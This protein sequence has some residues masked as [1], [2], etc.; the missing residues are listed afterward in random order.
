L[1]GSRVSSRCTVLYTSG[2]FHDHDRPQDDGFESAL[3]RTSHT[4]CVLP[5]ESY[6]AVETWT[7]AWNVDDALTLRLRCGI[8]FYHSNDWMP[9]LKTGNR[10]LLQ[11]S[12]LPPF[13]TLS[14]TRHTTRYRLNPNRCPSSVLVTPSICMT[15]N[16]DCGRIITVPLRNYAESTI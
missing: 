15:H 2:E 6:C 12:H 9:T 5:M 11:R 3:L 16:K 13:Q 8:S 10:L 14:V 1:V 4:S 7:L